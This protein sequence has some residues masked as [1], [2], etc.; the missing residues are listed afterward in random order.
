MNES[1]YAILL[2]T[3]PLFFVI[4]FVFLVIVVFAYIHRGFLLYE[5]DIR[6]K[7]ELDQKEKII[8]S[9]VKF[10]AKS[11]KRISEMENNKDE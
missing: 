7:A 3:F 2:Y 8:N 6:R 4:F 9:L 5:E 11:L 1:I 10:D